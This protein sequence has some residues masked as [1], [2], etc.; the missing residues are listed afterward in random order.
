MGL[1]DTNL[2]LMATTLTASAA[3]TSHIDQGAANRAIGN[4]MYMECL[5]TTTLDSTEEDATLTL[6]IQG[7]SDTAF[8]TVVTLA[9][10]DAVA[11]ASLAAGYVIRVRVPALATAY[12]YL[13]GYLTVGTHNFTSGA[14][15]VYFVQTPFIEA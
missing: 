7:D 4:E 11:E 15:K 1:I 5:V 12:R 13:R 10:S 3:T 8:G 14:V 6:S 2:E 9:S